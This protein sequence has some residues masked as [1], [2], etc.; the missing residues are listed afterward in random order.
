MNT[1]STMNT[2]QII[3]ITTVLSYSRCQ[4]VSLVVCARDFIVT[5]RVNRRLASTA[6]YV[7]FAPSRRKQ[8]RRVSKVRRVTEPS[9]CTEFY[10]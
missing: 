7:A 9:K 10:M 1:T 3:N 6:S 5:T 4:G 8:L 2:I